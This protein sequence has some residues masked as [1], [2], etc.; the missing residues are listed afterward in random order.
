MMKNVLCFATVTV[1]T[2]LLVACSSKKQS[3]GH[4]QEEPMEMAGDDHSA[5]ADMQ[6][7]AG[8]PTDASIYNVSSAWKTR[9]GNTIKLDSL[10]GK[11]QVVAM[12]YT[13]CEHAC[14]RIL[15]DMKR[16]EGALN[17]DALSKTNFTIVSI[18]P[19][20][21][22]PQR[23][24]QFADENNLSDN[25]WTLLNGDQGDIL[26]LAALLGFKYKRVSETDFTHSN[27]ITV[28]NKEGEVTYQRNK[29]VDKP[30]DAVSSIEKLASGG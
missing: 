23:L 9:Y 16:I 17:Q 24:R 5:H 1:V 15:A 26:E 4:R 25:R 3:D 29:L 12:V 20:R 27:M 19:E 21:D 6:M 8:E 10:R 28:L 22:S 13:Y 14:P 11:V 30:T 7:G 18:D 2:L